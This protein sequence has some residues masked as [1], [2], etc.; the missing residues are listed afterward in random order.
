MK[1]TL[2]VCVFIGAALTA[3]LTVSNPAGA[4]GPTNRTIVVINKSEN[5][6]PSPSGFVFNSPIY[7]PVTNQ[8]L[9]TDSGSCDL[10]PPRDGIEDEYLCDTVF[11][12]TNGTVTASGKQQASATVATGAVTGGTG[13]LRGCEGTIIGELNTST[14]E[15]ADFRITLALTEC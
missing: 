5:V 6:L 12:F 4:T 11:T 3:T 2:A 14:P 15:P 9:G 13:A 1:K 8:V 7:H 10:L